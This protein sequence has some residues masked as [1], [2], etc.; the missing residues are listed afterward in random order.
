MPTA[1][2]SDRRAIVNRV[3]I[4]ARRRLDGLAHGDH[5][6]LIPGPGSEPGET[7]LYVAGD[8]VRR[9][10]WSATARTQTV[11]VR[12]PIADREIE[13][14]VVLDASASLAFGTARCTKLDLALEAATLVTMSASSATD[15]VS[16]TVLVDG[17]TVLIPPASGRQSAIAMLMRLA[18]YTPTDGGGRSDL[19][20]TLARWAGRRR[21]FVIVISDFLDSGDWQRSL[22]AI[23]HR[24]EVL[25]VEIVDPRE[26]ELPDVGFI[27]LTD[28]E[29]GRSRDIDL[30]KGQLRDRYA[31]AAVHQRAT[32]AR[33]IRGAGAAHVQLRTDGDPVLALAKFAELR[34]RGVA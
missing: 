4:E 20:A 12:Q 22:R 15:R 9:I 1:V 21:Q 11:Q 14:A 30:S 17:K 18:D 33:A 32:I 10:D 26:M 29:T 8:D 31:A 6:G 2:Q 23:G 7:R 24:H 13:L 19:A 5:R 27:T 25:C 16:A 3:R 28:P 34:R